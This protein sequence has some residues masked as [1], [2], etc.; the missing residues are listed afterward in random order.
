VSYDALVAAVGPERY[1]SACEWARRE[2]EW[3]GDLANVPH[4]LSD[5]WE[6]DAVPMAERLDIALRFFAEMP[7]YAHLMYLKG[8]Y[9]HLDD[10][11]RAVVWETYREALTGSDERVAHPVSYSLWVDFFEDRATVAAA[12]S[13]MT[14]AD[15]PARGARLRRV[16][17]IAGPV[18]WPVKAALFEELV[19]DPAWHPSIRRAISD[20]ATDILGQ[21]DER[22]AKRW[23]RRVGG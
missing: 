7:C 6:D 18:P 11:L 17:G 2:G 22:D 5:V 21:I 9:R 13:E 3:P 19:G 15:K 4:E 23:R 16:L 8:W 14:R 1:R 10:T 20:S 12:W